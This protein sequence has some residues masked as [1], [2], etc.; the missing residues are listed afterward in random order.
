MARY[1]KINI[2]CP[3][4]KHKFIM[5]RRIMRTLDDLWDKM[6]EREKHE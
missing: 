1:E 5:Q 2:E 4:C 6:E 3:K